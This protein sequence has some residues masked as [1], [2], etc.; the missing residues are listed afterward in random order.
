MK[1]HKTHNYL[2]PK[3]PIF[4]S[5]FQAGLFISTIA[6]FAFYCAMLIISQNVKAEGSRVNPMWVSAPTMKE[7]INANRSALF[8]QA[9]DPW[10]GAETPQITMVYFTDFNCPYCKK[11]EPEL[12]KL[13][14]E[15]PQLKVIVK[16]VPL[17]GQSSVEAVD[18]AQRVWMNEPDK[19]LKL[20]EMLMA[21][22]RRLDSQ[23]IAKVA[24]MTNTSQ[25]LSQADASISPAISDNLEL[26]RGLRLGGT[27]SMVIGENIIVGLVP[28]S[29]LKQ[30]V[31]Q[32]LEAQDEHG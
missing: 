1:T 4:K 8:H 7:M 28:F 21:S 3:Q 18:F 31:E 30:Q 32:A 29:Q 12:D 23:T 10:K 26:M 6:A 9:D 5:K 24:A 22:P 27:P 13:M 15:Y 20:K 16:M 25:W 17:Q 19:Y 2:G 14:A 11:L